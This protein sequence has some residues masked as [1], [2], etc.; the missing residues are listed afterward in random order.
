MSI[1]AE[2]EAMALQ[3]AVFIG[4]LATMDDIDTREDFVSVLCDKMIKGLA[5]DI[6]Y[7]LYSPCLHHGLALYGSLFR[8]KLHIECEKIKCSD[9]LIPSFRS[10]SS[11]SYGLKIHIHNKFNILS[12]FQFDGIFTKEYVINIRNYIFVEYY[13]CKSFY[14]SQSHLAKFVVVGQINEKSDNLRIRWCQWLSVTSTTNI[15]DTEQCTYVTPKK[16][17]KKLY[18]EVSPRHQYTQNNRLYTTLC[19][20]YYD[21]CNS[22]LN[23]LRNTIKYIQSYQNEGVASSYTDDVSNNVE[24]ELHCPARDNHS[25]A[26]FLQNIKSKRVVYNFTLRKKIVQLYESCV[27]YIMT[28]RNNIL[29]EINNE[30]E[31]TEKFWNKTYMMAA[32]LTTKLIQNQYSGYEKLTAYQ[33]LH[34]S[35][36]MCKAL[37]RRGPKVIR[38]FESQIWSHL[39][40][41]IKDKD[42]KSWVVH[43]NVAFSYKLIQVAAKTVSQE[44]NWSSIESIRRLNFSNKWVKKF[45]ERQKFSRFAITTV[46]KVIP[47]DEAINFQMQIGQTLILNNRLCNHEVWNF[48]ETGFCWA[49]APKHIFAPTDM[50]RAAGE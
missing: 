23:L 8:K 10:R 42:S 1:T 3:V 37:K 46:V 2:D 17:T 35:D 36:S 26:Y 25:V 43:T 12:L 41:A 49:L 47:S 9:K 27:E 32:Q 7:V 31:D 39:I 28:N 44:A 29:I 6:D 24:D 19:K 33:I 30:D 45:L 21:D 4:F 38:D 13:N 11:L 14:L 5:T 22:Q 18:E 20:D 15:D 40:T 34:Y 16:R 50:D 48:D